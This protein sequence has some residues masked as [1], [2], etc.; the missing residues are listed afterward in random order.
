[1]NKEEK[2]FY[3]ATINPFVFSKEAFNL[4]DRLKQ[5]HARME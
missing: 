2:T 3:P 5:A 1:V 4:F